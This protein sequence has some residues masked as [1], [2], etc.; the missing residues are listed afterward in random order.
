M[1]NKKE[2]LKFYEKELEPLIIALK[3]KCRKEKMP[4]FIGVCIDQGTI[5]DGGPIKKCEKPTYKYDMVTPYYCG[6]NMTPDP[7]AECI[8]V[9]NGFHAVPNASDIN[10]NDYTF[11]QKDFD[12]D[13]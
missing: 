8:K 7:I 10:D 12:E 2:N 5:V 11:L 6:I 9:A 1:Q 3:N 4:M 13:L